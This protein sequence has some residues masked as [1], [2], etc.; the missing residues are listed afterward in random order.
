MFLMKPSFEIMDHV[1]YPF[2]LEVVSVA[3]GFC[4]GKC[5]AG[6]IDERE[7]AIRARIK[8]GHESVIEHMG[9]SV[10]FMVDRAIAME[11]IRHRVASYTQES[12]RYCNYASEK[13]GGHIR[14]IMPLHV[15]EQ[16]PEAAYDDIDFD[17]DGSLYVQSVDGQLIQ[18][19][20]AIQDWVNFLIHAEFAYRE[21]V[22]DHR[23]PPEFARSV[24]P[25]ATATNIMVTANMREWRHIFKLRALGTTGRP[26]PQMAE[27]MRPL[28]VQC[29][30]EFPVFFE[31][32]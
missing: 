31:D 30:E 21:L 7:N 25:N 26:H 1:S 20:K 32:L 17:P 5:V 15:S 8:S 14:F 18:C 28:L 11:M 13:Y 29:K 27:V 23:W 4:Y 10:R 2:M 3:I 19:T 9:F 6:S 24:L 22:N 12:T 16:L